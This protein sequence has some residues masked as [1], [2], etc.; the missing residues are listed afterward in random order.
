MAVVDSAKAGLQA[1]PRATI[2]QLR[3]PALTAAALEQEAMELV[4]SASVPVLV[5]S[6][7]DVAMASGAAGVNLPERDISVA[8]ARTLLG[9]RLVGRSVHSIAS[10]QQAEREGADFVIFGPVWRSASHPDDAEPAGLA[11]L[12]RVVRAVGIPVLAIGGVTAERIAEC[13]AAGAA[14]YGAIGMF[15]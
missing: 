15:R 11:A 7:C 8:D 12:E 6:R 3:A 4:A 5:S 9:R 10:A 13:L 1:A 2:I 14:G